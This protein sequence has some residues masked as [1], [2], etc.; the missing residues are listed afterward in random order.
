MPSLLI[1]GLHR[2]TFYSGVRA[3]SLER[4]HIMYIR[5][6]ELGRENSDNVSSKR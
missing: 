3:V 1:E 2:M 5:Y 6:V 4:S